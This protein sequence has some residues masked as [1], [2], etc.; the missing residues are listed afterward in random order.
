MWYYLHHLCQLLHQE[1][2]LFHHLSAPLYQYRFQSCSWWIHQCY[3]EKGKIEIEDFES[4]LRHVKNKVLGILKKTPQEMSRSS[5]V[6]RT[7]EFLR[8]FGAGENPSK[9]LRAAEKIKEEVKLTAMVLWFS[10][11]QIFCFARKTKNQM[12]TT[13]CRSLTIIHQCLLKYKST[14]IVYQQILYITF[15]SN[16]TLA[17][18]LIYLQHLRRPL[19]QELLIVGEICHY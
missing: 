6:S 17:C 15:I 9:S 11:S 2:L 3:L 10:V 8:V 5:K 14:I 7:F 19:H 4:K 1:F 18:D 13:S 12:L 16:Q